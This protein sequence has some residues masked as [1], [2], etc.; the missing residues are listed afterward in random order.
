M[1]QP[2]T[3]AV[4]ITAALLPFVVLTPVHAAADSIRHFDI[5]TQA[6]ATALGEFARQSDRQILFSTEVVDA[7]RTDSLKGDLE[8]EAALRELLKGTGLT[9]RVTADNTILVDHPRAG[10]AA[11]PASSGFRL[12]LSSASEAPTP[13]PE[14]E[15]IRVRVAQN[16]QAGNSS[17]SREGAENKT[18]LE[19]VIVTA[20][21][22][23]ERSIDVPMSVTAISGE[24]LAAAGTTNILDLSRTVPG[25]S[26]TETG[27]GRQVVAIRGI[28]T[29]RGSS[30]LTGVY[31]DEMPLSGA[32]NGFVA[33]Y[34]DLRVIDLDRVEVLKGPQ[35]TLFGE[36]AAGGV[37]RFITMDPDLQRTGGDVS[38]QFS[39][40]ADGGF[41]QKVTGVV[42]VPLEQDV[43]GIRVAGVYEDASGWIDQPSIGRKDIND[44]VLKDVRL[45]AL[46]APNQKLEVKGLVELHRNEG[47]ASN[48]VNQLSYD[49]SLFVQAIFPDG[50][51]DYFDDYD[52]YNLTVTYDFGFAEL[53]SST[54]HNKASSRQSL[55]QFV[56]GE[57]VP[58]LE[59]LL[60]EFLL[61]S[62]ITS[63][64]LRLTSAGEG[65]FNWTV[66]TSYKDAELDWS[67]GHGFDTSFLGGA[68]QSRSAYRGA[69]TNELT[70]W[71]GFADASWQLT[72]RFSLGAGL[73]YFHGDQ[74]QIATVPSAFT[75]AAASSKVTWRAYGKFAARE[76]MNVYF[77]IGSGFRAGGFNNPSEVPRG[78][79]QTYGPENSLFYELGAKTV[80]WGG[81][82]RFDTAV[83]AGKWNDMQIDIATTSPVDGGY[84][85]YTTNGQDAE[86]KGV[87]AELSWAAT[88]RLTLTFAGD[89]TDTEITWVDPANDAPT[90]HVGDKLSQVP[91]Y[92]FSTSAEYRFQWSPAVPGSVRVSFDRTGKSYDT[93]RSGFP[94]ILEQV[95]VAQPVE[96]LSLR[97]GGDWSGWR[98]ALYG[99]NLTDERKPLNAHLTGS[100]AQARPR[101]VG[102]IVSKSF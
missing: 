55:T 10:K 40:T 8:P 20:Q 41:S 32:Q 82:V 23:A 78:A 46:Y 77:N 65:P 11:Q 64:E 88:E 30:S 71:A 48:I 54:S 96:F 75:V 89:V 86:I 2:A 39:D 16:A 36:G 29:V 4:Q 51:T 49:D 94:L 84:L 50:R 63:Q 79:S 24:K 99:N 59:I 5:E 62:S 18:E 25:L 21:K 92:K 101:T 12:R 67:Y 14:R 37:I 98:W 68:V 15:R 85:Q 83:Y 56:D 81:R 38:A 13:L 9:Y 97:V 27:P 91:D 76:N 60:T 87:E 95:D 45:K 61:D 102:V 58:Y 70:D 52:L 66:G 100:K 93:A 53:L 90:F 35:G 44:S 17:P 1:S 3:R 47:G 57:P 33:T 69:A 74:E 28:S 6:L 80:L 26:V 73:R 42:N 72:R 7:K 34:A 19:E 31:L 43:F 22:R